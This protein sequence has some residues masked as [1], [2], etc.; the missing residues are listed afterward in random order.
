VMK[1]AF[2]GKGFCGR[3]WVRRP[4]G[5]ALNPEY[6]VGKTAHPVKLNVG[7]CFC[8]AGQGYMVIF[9]ENMDA[10]MMRKILDEN[11]LP[12]AQLR[13]PSDPPQAWHLLH[14]NDKKFKSRIVTELLHNKG[15]GCLEFP[16][17]T[18]DLNPIE[19]LWGAM[20]RAVEKRECDT[21][22]QL[23]DVIADKWDKVDEEL[24]RTLAHSI[25]ARCQIVIEARGWHTK[26]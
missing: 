4:V 18:P 3:T 6:C 23:Q 1:N 13:F 8:A 26:Y 15:V 25:P 10:L 14:D 20:A 12:S 22:M 9:N 7:A 11:L 21:L 2:Y 19:N 17:Y 16:P 24:M 5:E